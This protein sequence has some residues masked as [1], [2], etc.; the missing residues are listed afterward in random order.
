MAFVSDLNQAK[1]IFFEIEVLGFDSIEWFLLQQ[2]HSKTRFMMNDDRLLEQLPSLQQLLYRLICCQ[3]RE[4][5]FCSYFLNGVSEFLRFFLQPEGLACHNYLVQYALALVCRTTLT[6]IYLIG[7]GSFRSSSIFEMSGTLGNNAGVERE[8]Q[9]LLFNQWWNYQSCWFG[10]IFPCYS[11]NTLPL[12]L[13]M[14]LSLSPF[15]QFFDMPKHDAIRALDVYKRAGKQVNFFT[16][17]CN[18]NNK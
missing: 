7:N 16:C 8:L 14:T 1:F 18:S 11:V 10:M 6:I 2:M 5:C 4:H 3:V 13:V 12:V 9:D 17:F 15:L